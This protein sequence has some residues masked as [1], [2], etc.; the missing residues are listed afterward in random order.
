MVA[1]NI[2]RQE[3]ATGFA[4]LLN[5]DVG[6]GQQSHERRLPHIAKTH[7]FNTVQAVEHVENVLYIVAAHIAAFGKA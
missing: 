6:L 1:V 7:N 3:V 2:D 4:Q 5:P